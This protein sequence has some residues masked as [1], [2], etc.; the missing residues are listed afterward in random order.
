MN[1]QWRSKSDGTGMERCK[2]RCKVRRR[3]DHNKWRTLTLVAQSSRKNRT[4]M[5]KTVWDWV[6]PW[7]IARYYTPASHS[8]AVSKQ[9]KL[10][11]YQPIKTAAVGTCTENLAKIGSVFF[12]QVMRMDRQTDRQTN[13]LCTSLEGE[14]I[15]SLR[16]IFIVVVVV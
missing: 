5:S 2:E 14:V 8:G 16:W 11:Y 9:S 15:D 10:P 6:T 12:F 7:S 4:T 1:H 13:R 3:G